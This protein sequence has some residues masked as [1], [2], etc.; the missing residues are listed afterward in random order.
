MSGETD[1]RCREIGFHGTEKTKTLD[2]RI[3]L[4][5]RGAGANSGEYFVR[6]CTCWLESISQTSL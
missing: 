1:S 6:C 2:K 4:I 3:E 5:H